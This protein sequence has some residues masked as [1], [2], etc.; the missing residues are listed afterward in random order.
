MEKYF[1]YSHKISK[2][3]NY[4]IMPYLYKK[5]IFIIIQYMFIINSINVFFNYQAILCLRILE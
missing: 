1:F 5:L 3:S 4:F 2:I